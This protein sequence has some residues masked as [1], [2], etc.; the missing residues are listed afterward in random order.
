MECIRCHK[1]VPDGALFC[2]WCGKRQPD[3]AP[4]VQRKKRRRP[5]GSGS[6]YKLKDNRA[7]PFVALS[8]KREVIGT[9]ATSGEAVQAQRNVLIEHKISQKALTF[10]HNERMPKTVKD[11]KQWRK[12]K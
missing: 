6:V 10:A 4:P 11:T 9:Y 1:E 5:K 7:K 2:P 12:A 3:Y 8:S